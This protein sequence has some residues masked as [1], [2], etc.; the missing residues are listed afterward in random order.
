M[1]ATTGVHRFQL[2]KFVVTVLCDGVGQIGKP[3]GE[4]NNFINAAPADWLPACRA[5]EETLGPAT[6]LGSSN[7]L[8]LD[9]GQHRVLVDTGNGPSETEPGELLDRLH[10]TGVDPVSID[11]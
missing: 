8:L 9:H 5:V 7:L 4:F 6:Y 10:D 2:G 11:T 3:N 1:S